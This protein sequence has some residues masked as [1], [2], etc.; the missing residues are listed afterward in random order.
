MKN[1]KLIFIL[2]GI[3]LV[4]VAAIFLMFKLFDNSMTP[5]EFKNHL[6]ALGYE[7]TEQT[8]PVDNTLT[9]MVATKSDVT[10]NVEYFDFKNEVEAK[11]YYKSLKKNLINY[12]TSTTQDSETNGNIFSKQISISE[13]DY[14]VIS[15]IKKTLIFIDGTSDFQSD[16]ES[17]LKKLKY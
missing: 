5:E 7:V 8:S 14:V 1:K 11:K 2:I 9:Y 3:V 16:I 4:G 6:A 15:R 13:T 17:L 12:I 10:Y